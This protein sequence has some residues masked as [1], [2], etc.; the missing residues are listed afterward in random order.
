VA[1]SEVVGFAKT[2]GL[3]DVAGALPRALAQRGHDC[4]VLMPLYRCARLS[5]HPMEATPHTFEVPVGPRSVQGRLWRST[6]PGSQVP[7]YLIE[8]PGYYD[9]DDSSQGLGLYQFTPP[10]GSPRD[11]QDNCARFVFFCR[12]V[13]E[14]IR[15]LD[16][17][18]DVLHLNDWQTGLVPVYLREDYARLRDPLLRRRYLGLRTLFT[19]HNIAYQGNFWH[20][21]MLLAGLGWHLYN[22]HQLEFHRHLSFL[23][24]GLV[25][26]DL[27]STVSPTYAREIQT[28]LYGYGMQ[29]VLMQRSH[30]LV[31]IV[32]G[33]DYGTW[34]PA[35]DALLPARYSVDAVQPGKGVCK[36]ALQRHYGLAEEPGRPLLGMV[37]RLVEQKGP[38]LLGP[39]APRFLDQG[40]QLVVLGSGEQRYQRMLEDLRNRYP[41]QVGLTLGFDE[42]L[43][44]RIEAGADLFLMPSLYEPSGLNQLYSMKYGTPPVVR[45]TGGLADTVTDTTPATLADS[46]AT[47]FSFT[48]YSADALFE[49]V[50]RALDL[51]RG[52]P[53]PWGRVVRN[54]MLQDWSWDRSAAEYEKLYQRLLSME[55]RT[56]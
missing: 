8:Q 56:Q 11:Y 46:T 43:A 10:G 51:Y 19:I 20:W 44:H 42:A 15:L 37:A 39:A 14:A 13:L 38:D 3:A 18:P 31:G 49:A 33:V 53:E 1:A 36:A 23:K 21:D 52:P 50:R 45:A 32:N 54:A 7:I 22:H 35:R 5:G 55:E 28:F 48:P 25:F 40:A 47:G 30:Q 17:W 12:A 9:R 26:A 16:F 6:L 24:A 41:R 2:G 29:G 4:A 34:D 27:L